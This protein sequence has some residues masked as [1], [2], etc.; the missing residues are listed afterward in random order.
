MFEID[1]FDEGT[2]QISQAIA[3]SSAFSIVV[4]EIRSQQS[5]CIARVWISPIFYGGGA[6]LE[7]IE[8]KP[9]LLFK[10]SRI[11]EQKGAPQ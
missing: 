1:Q 5:K 2:K 8:E 3:S 4:E 7:Y 6:F 11:N 10:P 9:Y